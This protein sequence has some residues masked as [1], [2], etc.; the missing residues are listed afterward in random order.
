MGSVNDLQ[1]AIHTLDHAVHGAD[2]AFFVS[3]ISLIYEYRLHVL[4]ILLDKRVIKTA[5][6]NKYRHTDRGDENQR[7]DRNG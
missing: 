7:G 3:K 4:V 6:I 2:S 5:F 1:F